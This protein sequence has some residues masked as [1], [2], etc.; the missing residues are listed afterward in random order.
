MTRRR[1]TRTPLSRERLARVTPILLTLLTAGAAVPGA[2]AQAPPDSLAELAAQATRSVVLI[3]VQTPSGSRQGSGFIVDAGGT[4]L[5][6]QHVVRGAESVRVK[7][8]SGDLY[9]V[10]EILSVD[11]R[12]DLAVIQIATADSGDVRLAA[13]VDAARLEFQELPYTVT[14]E[15]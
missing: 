12:R 9:D 14:N 6:N 13:N 4:I 10:V 8:A 11:E 5:T 1:N 3:D 7:L 15:A 2:A